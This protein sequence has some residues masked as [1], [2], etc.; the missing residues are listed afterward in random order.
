MLKRSKVVLILW[1]LSFCLSI[2]S[3][4]QETDI[5]HAKDHPLLTRYEGAVITHY[6]EA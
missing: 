5:P 2:S 4:G 6:D 3:Y 1:L